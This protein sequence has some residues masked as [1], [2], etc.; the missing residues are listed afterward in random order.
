MASQARPLRVSSDLVKSI[1]VCQGHKAFAGN[2]T[3][4][5]AAAVVMA[6]RFFCSLGMFQTTWQ[7][8]EAEAGASGLSQ[9]GAIIQS[10]IRLISKG[11]HRRP[12]GASA[13]AS[14]QVD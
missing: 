2:L 6:V 3:T 9:C 5:K 14:T 13:F 7:D 1:R 11:H 12:I 10:T 4:A 8:F